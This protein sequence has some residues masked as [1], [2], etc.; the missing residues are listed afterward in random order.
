MHRYFHMGISKVR[1]SL[2]YPDGTIRTPITN[3]FGYY[4]FDDVM[5]G[6]TYILSVRSKGYQFNNPDQVV[7]VSD[8]LNDIDFTAMPISDIR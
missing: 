7:A 2:T 1:V 4:R 8:E 6:D 5:A 3:A